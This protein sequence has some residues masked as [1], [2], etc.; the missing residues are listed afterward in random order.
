[1]D[2]KTFYGAYRTIPRA[3]RVSIMKLSHQLWNT[4]A[5]NNKYCS[6]NDA[7]HVCTAQWETLDHVHQCQHIDAKG[8]RK[9][10]LQ[11]VSQS[12]LTSTPPVLLGVIDQ[13]LV[14]WTKT[15]PQPSLLY[16]LPPLIEAVLEEQNK[17]G[18]GGF[19]RGH[20][21]S[22][23]HQAYIATSPPGEKLVITKAC[24]RVRQIINDGLLP[25][26]E[27]AFGIVPARY[28]VCYWRWHKFI[29]EHLQ[30]RL[31]HDDHH[32]NRP[33]IINCNK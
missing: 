4:N 29:T 32:Y 1:M 9:E 6:T 17:I 14:R 5:E 24:K 10:A 8:P 16:K 25:A 2:W 30:F 7:C 11:K 28:S 33:A 3:H 31:M 19:L 15:E 12:L 23:W 21:S 27:S 26:L 13:V 22:R 20:I 18:W